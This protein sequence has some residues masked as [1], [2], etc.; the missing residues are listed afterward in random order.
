[1]SF[2][3]W[4][5]VL[6]KL[7]DEGWKVTPN[8]SRGFLGGFCFSSGLLILFA[9][10]TAAACSKSLLS[11]SPSS[12]PLPGPSLFLP[13]QFLAKQLFNVLVEGC[14]LLLMVQGY[15]YT[16]QVFLA[17]QISHRPWS[18]LRFSWPIH[19][20]LSHVSLTF[21]RCLYTVSW[22]PSL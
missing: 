11:T 12:A 16:S 21:F 8:I 2:S 19:L 15:L 20:S 4:E 5:S 17:Q 14:R 18:Y 1:M 22:A 6:L 13:L 3:S 9:F 10:F 7:P